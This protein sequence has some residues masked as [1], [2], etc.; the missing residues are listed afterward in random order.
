MKFS[1]ACNNF[2][3]LDFSK[4]IPQ[5][6][7]YGKPWF[8]LLGDMEFQNLIDSESTNSEKKI[9]IFIS[10]WSKQF[11]AQKSR[12]MKVYWNSSPFCAKNCFDQNKAK[13][14]IVWNKVVKIGD[15]EF[16]NWFLD[17]MIKLWNSEIKSL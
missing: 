9:T 11:S 15:S 8:W 4:I 5:I 2:F 7:I 17:P 1:Y 16:Y 12:L 13:K 10:I 14:K 6:W 3:F